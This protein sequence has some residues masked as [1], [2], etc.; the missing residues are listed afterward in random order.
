MAS[1]ARVTMNGFMLSTVT[2]KPLKAPQAAPSS[3]AARDRSRRPARAR[4]AAARSTTPVKATTEPG[5]R[6]MPPV[7]ITKVS[8]IATM[9]ISEVASR[10]DSM[11]AV[12]RKVGVVSGEIERDRHEGDDDGELV[13]RVPAAGSERVGRAGVASG[14]EPRCWTSFRRRTWFNPGRRAP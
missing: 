9:P 6:S 7:T 12:V 4:A 8:P 1:T 11:L 2:A 5:D 3:D 10:I 13:E 14:S